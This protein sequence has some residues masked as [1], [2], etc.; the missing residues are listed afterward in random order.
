LPVLAHELATGR[1]RAD[2]GDAFVQIGFHGGTP[3]G[4]WG[5]MVNR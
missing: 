3:Q 4:Q 1:A 2:A 5:A